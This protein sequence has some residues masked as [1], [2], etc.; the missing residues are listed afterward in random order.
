MQCII[1]Q[2]KQVLIKEEEEEEEEKEDQ[3]MQKKW[4]NMDYVQA[5]R[6]NDT[7]RY[8]TRTYTRQYCANV[9]LTIVSDKIS[10]NPC[11]IRL[12]VLRRKRNTKEG[13]NKQERRD[14]SLYIPRSIPRRSGCHR[15]DTGIMAADLYANG[16]LKSTSA[17]AVGR[18]M[19]QR[20]SGA[21]GAAAPMSTEEEQLKFQDSR[22]LATLVLGRSRRISPDVLPSCSPGVFRQ[23]SFRSSTSTPSVPSKVPPV[24]TLPPTTRNSRGAPASATND[25]CASRAATPTASIPTVA[26]AAAAVS[27]R[28]GSSRTVSTASLSSLS[29]S[30]GARAASK[31]ARL[32]TALASKMATA[33]TSTVVQGWPNTKDDYE[34]KEVI[35]VGATA[36]VHAAFCIPRQEKCAIKRINLEKWNTNMDELLKEIQ[37]MSSC[38]HENVVTYYTSFVVKEELWLVLRLLEGGSLLDIIKHKTRTTNC[39]HGVFDEATIA[40]VLREV[41]K[42]LEYFHSNGQIHRDIKAGNI[43]LGEDGTVQ[44]ADFGVSAWLATGRDLSR[45]KVRHTFVGTPC[46]MAPEV[47]EQDHGYDFKAD[48]WSLGITAIEMASG[49]APYHKYPPMKVLML[50]LQNDPPTLDTAADDKDQYKAYGKTFRK[51]IVDCLQKDP[52]KRPTATELLKHPFFKK[53]KDKKYLQQTLVAIGPSLET[54]VQKASKRQPGTSGRLHRTV[55]GEWVWS[56]EE[57]NGDSSSDECKETLPVNTIEKTSSDEEAGEPDEFY[58]QIRVAPSQ[59]ALPETGQNTPIN[60]VLRLRNEKREL[61]DI[62]FDFTVGVDSAQGIAAE[63]VAAGLVDGKDIVVIETNL[64]KLIESGGQLRTV[65]FSLNTGYAMNEIPDDKALIGFAQIS[66]TE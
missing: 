14:P 5:F 61:N 35:G 22:F 60:L 66:I 63:L 27:P 31:H 28:D 50:T 34:L 19:G 7:K 40:T 26:A 45:Q 2:K 41:L 21:L 64:K 48:I 47:M 9:G 17:R 3:V 37:A 38:N 49:T 36:V 1:S 6:I 10:K 65:T 53:A 16:S 39:K 43:L 15:T 11:R 51:M 29:L 59:M 24:A 12:I 52:T 32:G 55:T 18:S 4:E 23:K 62:R 58:G 42:G 13:R 25:R 33:S 44:I 20:K 54:R 46:W 57:N 56:E 8:I 30:R